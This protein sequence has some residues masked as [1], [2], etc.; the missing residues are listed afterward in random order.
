M[1][2]CWKGLTGRSFYDTIEY[3]MNFLT[4]VKDTDTALS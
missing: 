2:E 4:H 3:S 1:I